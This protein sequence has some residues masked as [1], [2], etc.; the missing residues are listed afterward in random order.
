MVNNHITG[1]IS[2]LLRKGFD[3]ARLKFL[4]R[5]AQQN[6]SVVISD[7]KGNVRR[8]PAKDL[9]AASKTPKQHNK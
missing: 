6:G 3:Q 1:D 7:A 8:V 2:E 9:L 4:Q 5:K